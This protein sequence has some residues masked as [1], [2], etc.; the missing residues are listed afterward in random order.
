MTLCVGF[1]LYNLVL[2]LFLKVIFFK[3]GKKKLE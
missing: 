3:K 1:V 2:N